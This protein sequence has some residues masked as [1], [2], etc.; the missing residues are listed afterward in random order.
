A[1]RQMQYQRLGRLVPTAERG[2]QHFETLPNRIYM[3]ADNSRSALEI[4]LVVEIGQQCPA[5]GHPLPWRD[6]VNGLKKAGKVACDA[7]RV[8]GF[9]QLGEDIDLGLADEAVERLHVP[10]NLQ[11]LAQAGVPRRGFGE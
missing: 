7:A 8:A 2:L 11:G 3:H 5:H 4:V 9:K 1:K 10:E 6:M